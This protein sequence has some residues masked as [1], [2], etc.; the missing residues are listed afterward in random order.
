MQTNRFLSALG[1]ALLLPAPSAIAA[2]LADPGTR[3]EDLSATTVDV[4]VDISNAGL[5]VYTYS[6]TAGARNTGKISEF[7]VD[8]SCEEATDPK[9]FSPSDFPT[10]SMVSASA[11]GKHVPVA[12]DAPEGQSFQTGVAASNEAMWS[13]MLEPSESS[14]GLKI[15]SPYPPG[16][17]RYTLYPSVD[18]NMDSYDYEGLDPEDP[19]IP[20]ID[21]WTVHGITTGPACREQE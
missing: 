15:I 11:D 16:M 6:V 3:N 17:R 12:L 9:E 20:W 19:T 7:A 13:V 14:T 1:L 2:D 18:Y 10:S 5:Y 8:I 4:N 21:D